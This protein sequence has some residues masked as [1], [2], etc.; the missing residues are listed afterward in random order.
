MHRSLKKLNS[1]FIAGVICCI[2]YQSIAGGPL[3]LEGPDG[4]TAVNYLNPTIT[5][6][7]EGGDLGSLS[8]AEANTLLSDAF[9]LWNTV[10]TSNIELVIDSQQILEDI[11]L[12]NFE[13][14]LPAV[15]DSNFNADDNLN[16]IVY[17]D[18]GEIIDA[19]FGVGASD[20]TI[21]FAASII[22][23]GA[24]HFDEGYAV[25][26]G[27]TLSP[28][29]SQLE[30]K[31]LIAHEIAHFTGLD[32]S[33]V[34]IINTETNFGFPAI[35][36]TSPREDY[37]VMY[38]FVCRDIESLHSDDISA[39]SALYP[40]A[41]INDK[42]GILEG[43]FVDEPGLPISGANIWLEN[44]TTG[45]PYSIVSGYLKQP[46]GYYKLLLPAGSYTLHA[47]S[48][49]TLFNGGSGIG[50][51]S[52]DLNDLSFIS[53]HPI[54]PVTYQGETQGNAEVISITV[55]QTTGI[56]FSTVGTDTEP[57]F[58]VFSVLNTSGDRNS[59]IFDVIGSTDH[60]T[61][62]LLVVLLMASRWRKTRN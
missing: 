51:Y 47:N 52:T 14:F 13:D 1:F 60:N 30:F 5:V 4:H 39:I 31:L 23:I 37:P 49:N 45:E 43:H 7:V 28:P 38:P 57:V 25:I 29:L 54:T 3:V 53:P 17:D 34:N 35:C 15:D 59:D 2:S 24:S 46:D 48:I 26:N 18:N 6:H 12:N 33:Q 11:N 32:H 58:S 41:D 8:N 55:N 50:P 61:T 56:S 20:F 19:Y 36:S 16:P 42:F 10:E 62:L 21:G 9:K 44:T 22:T 27:K 40:A